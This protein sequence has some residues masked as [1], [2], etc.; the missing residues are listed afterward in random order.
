M[1]T[2]MI[3]DTSLDAMRR[4]M[5]EFVV[6]RDKFNSA[7]ESGNL[8]LAME[9]LNE[10][11]SMIDKEQQRINQML[12]KGSYTDDPMV[13]SA[14]LRDFY[15][16]TPQQETMEP[17]A[18]VNPTQVKERIETKLYELGYLY[19]KVTHLDWSPHG[20]RVMVS[21]EGTTGSYFGIFNYDENYF[22]S[23]PETRAAMRKV[24]KEYMESQEES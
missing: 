22:E 12:P 5:R 15:Q 16:S 18:G 21:T 13:E 14:S 19:D 20:P 1:D 2:G 11:K 23:T 9:I 3:T 4:F 24:H 8:I 6:L 17:D 7:Y 10:L